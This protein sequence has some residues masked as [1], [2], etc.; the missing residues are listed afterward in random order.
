MTIGILYTELT[1]GVTIIENSGCDELLVL[2]KEESTNGQIDSKMT[3]GIYDVLTDKKVD[4]EVDE[5]GANIQL[6]VECALSRALDNAR[7]RS[8]ELSLDEKMTI[9][10]K[11]MDTKSGKCMKEMHDIREKAGDWLFGLSRVPYKKKWP[12]DF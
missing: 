10:M 2:A 1:M 5:K 11:D 7:V 8:S 9:Q 12:D 6:G 4:I 3:S